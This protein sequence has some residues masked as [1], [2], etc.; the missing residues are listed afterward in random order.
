MP[1]VDIAQPLSYHGNRVI[2]PFDEV[3]DK[4]KP[5]RPE[6]SEEQWQYYSYLIQRLQRAQEDRDRAHPEF[7][8]KTY[9]EYYEQNEKI[10]HTFIEPV[11]NK[12]EEPLA[13]GT[14][15]SKLNTL[16]AH[17]DNLN[18]TPEVNAFDRNN[19]SL[20]EL[21]RAFS[22]IMAVEAEHDGGDDGGDREKRIL[23]QRELLKQGTVFVQDSWITRY[24]IKKKLNKKYSGE[25][26]NYAG[27]TEK[28]IKA[29]EGSSRDL[30][31]GPNV[32]LGDITA[33]S[34]NDQPFVFTVE[35]MPY[36]RAKQIYGHFENWKYVTPGKPDSGTETTLSIGGRTI[37]DAKWR[38]SNVQDNHVEIIKYQDEARDEFMIMINGVMLLPPGFPLSAVTPDGRYNITKQT[39][40]I[41]NAQF[42][43]GKSFVSSGAVYEISKALDRF[44]R[45]F[46]L[47]T[48][49]SI[50]PPYIN[51][52]NRVIPAKALNPGNISMGIP[53]NALLPIG[54]E[55]QGVTSSEYQ[56]FKEMQDQIEKSTI[57]SIFQ[58]QQASG[59][60]TATEV[61]E[62]QR[63]A[64]LT[65]GLIITACTL[66]EIKLG[67]LRLYNILSHWLEPIGTNAD[68]SPRYRTANRQTM[69]PGAGKGERRVIPIS[70]ELPTPEAIRILSLQ[71]E[72]K[73]GFPVRR[74]YLNPKQ[75]REAQI[76][77]YITVE[78]R[79]QESSSYHK[80]L[81]REMLGDAITLAQLGASINIQGV[82]D[83]FSKVY[84]VDKANIFSGQLPALMGA[85]GGVEPNRVAGDRAAGNNMNPQGVAQPSATERQ[86]QPKPATTA[87]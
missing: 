13:T 26:S 65:L 46:E 6:Y 55:S 18:L 28:L 29:Y 80:L 62:V 39:L 64:R 31:Y 61:I 49:K 86:P 48:R 20:I 25:F 73:Y 51:T 45:L 19:K 22:D 9:L 69:I 59:G 30:L 35:S 66:L 67:Y 77:W 32:Y 63:Q 37:Y 82:T 10:A 56:I 12:A 87:A 50:T 52:T 36:D 38:L 44:I 72:K 76:T 41:I 79:E 7:S 4:N 71:D 68:G 81:F 58:G 16:A 23:R 8:G 78:P 75:I 70:G 27:H 54:T 15:E 5:R 24:K 17:I 74:S 84:N 2:N 3:P 60:A 1:Y 34:M 43:Y 85:G 21:G 83:E 42:A 57:S 53:P 11:A 33:F 47:K 40:Y 14:V